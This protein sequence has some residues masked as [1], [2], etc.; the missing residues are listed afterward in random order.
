[1]Q[2]R[3]CSRCWVAVIVA[4][5]VSVP[6]QQARAQIEEIVVTAQKRAENL[7]DVPIAVS[8]FSASA[9][10]RNRI[11]DLH[12]I[13]IRTPSFNIGQ[14]GPTAPELT[15]RGVGSTD[16]E[17]GS[18]RSVVLFVDEVYIGRA[19]TSTFD[20][21]DLERIEV[22]RGP[23]GSIFGRNVVGGSVNLITAQPSYD[24]NAKISLSAGN[25]GLFETQG[26]VT[27]GLSENVA[28]RLA[29]S[30][31]TRDGYYRNRL[32]DFDTAGNTETFNARGK[33]LFTP[34]DRFTATVTLELS[35][36]TMDGVGSAISQGATSDAE[37]LEE[38]NTRFSTNE[39]PSTDLQITDNNEFGFLD[40]E[41]A[42]LSA[43]LEWTTGIGD[44][45]VIPAIRDST[46]EIVR[47]LVG[48]AIADPGAPFVP[49]DSRTLGFSTGV[50]FESTAINEED[51]TA[52]SL[53]ARLASQDDGSSA[54]SWLA[55]LYFLD[56]SID[57]D[58][59][60]E[61]NFS[62]TSNGTAALSRPLFQQSVDVSSI[63][64]FG[65]I[66]WRFSDR[67]SASV[68]GRYTRDEKDF[69]L[70]VVNTLS[71]ADQNAILTV[72]PNAVFSLSPAATEFSTAASE[73]F[74]E[75]T[76]DVTL[77]FHSTDDILL[78][79]KASTGF[80]SG[81]FVGLGATE[82]LAQ[83]S[84]K[85]ETV[86]NYELG[87]KGQFF[88]RRLQINADVFSMEFEDLQLRDRQLLVPGDETTAIVTTVNAAEAEIKGFE[89]DFQFN[90]I[91]TLNIA[92]SMSLLDT[93]IVATAEG[94]TVNIGTQ[95]PRAPE[96]S[97]SVGFNYTIFGTGDSE[98]T[99]GADV[100]FTDSMF[101]DINEDTAGTESDHTLWNLNAIYRP[102][103]GN[104][105]AAIWG[106]N[107][108]DERYRTSV[109]SALGDDVGIITT[110]GAPRTYGVTLTLGF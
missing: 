22:L 84:F 23:Q 6:F 45:T 89:V 39:L 40:R 108:G 44:I 17:A 68:G 25:L 42:A 77:E 90:P 57:R 30:A 41:I 35:N 88:E 69:N 86:L 37:Y 82:D 67:L 94:S 43:R 109:Q 29:F 96:T 28:G 20:L 79:A 101:F 1:M 49:V 105:S 10:Q 3:I 13:A 83:R 7:Q 61:R 4:A 52:T 11:N 48:I 56:E 33:L 92:G 60:R 107:L 8:A 55:G 14:N 18:D 102:A 34:S 73:T 75:F 32:F 80:K 58:Q 50:G 71:V 9:I 93:E 100:Q 91:S 72:I 26:Y 95:L 15:I 24:P 66:Q 70:T 62:Q 110:V 65:Q 63:A 97:G 21:F 51:Y 12:E 27:G 16:R 47:D 31:R 54:L 81:G 103:D 78:Y 64:A 98:F 85:P 2:I 36:D 104:W 38:F 5:S 59:I 19:G 99:F 46:F 87:M 76:P 53:E 74:S 106:K